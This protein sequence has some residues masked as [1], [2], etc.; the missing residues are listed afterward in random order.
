MQQIDQPGNQ[1]Q[2]WEK[3]RLFDLSV[4]ETETGGGGATT[5]FSNTSTATA[6]D[7]S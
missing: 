6:P 2:P 5:D 1:K 4:M 7:A 3:P